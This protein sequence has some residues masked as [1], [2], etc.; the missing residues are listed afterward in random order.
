MVFQAHSHKESLFIELRRGDF[1]VGD[2]CTRYFPVAMLD[3]MCIEINQGCR[4]AFIWV[5]Y[6]DYICSEYYICNVVYS[7]THVGYITIYVMHYWALMKGWWKI[8]SLWGCLKTTNFNQNWCS[9]RTTTQK[10]F[11]GY[12]VRHCKA[13]NTTSVEALAAQELGPWGGQSACSPMQ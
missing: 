3:W 13:S 7:I 10:R 2:A 8:H 12:S 11:P 5:R 9:V 6:C 4:Y 1:F